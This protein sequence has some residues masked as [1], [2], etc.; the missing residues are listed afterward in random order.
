DSLF[1]PLVTIFRT[2]CF[3]PGCDD[4]ADG[5]GCPNLIKCKCPDPANC[6]TELYPHARPHRGVDLH[7]AVG[8]PVFAMASGVVSLP[9]VKP[10]SA[11]QCK[12]SYN[13]D[14]GC[15]EYFLGQKRLGAGLYINIKHDDGRETK[16]FHLSQRSVVHGQRV[17]I[18]DR[19]GETGD[20]GVALRQP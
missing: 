9:K 13:T 4:T 2:S 5:L 6:K 3:K 15:E 14:R 11:K 7:A 16:Y 10:Q 12:T 8:T 20:S 18:G 1:P 19:I 17:L